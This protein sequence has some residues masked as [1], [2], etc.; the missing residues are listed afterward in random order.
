MLAGRANNAATTMGH[1]DCSTKP[2][3]A[4]SATAAT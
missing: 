4:T 1:G 3:A 2:T